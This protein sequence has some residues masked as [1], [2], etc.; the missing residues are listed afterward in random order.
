LQA[1]DS[2]LE[3]ETEVETLL[4]MMG[5]KA[6]FSA[7]DRLHTHLLPLLSPLVGPTKPIFSRKC[8]EFRGEV[9]AR[10]R[11]SGQPC[12]HAER[13]RKRP[14]ATFA[15]IKRPGIFSSV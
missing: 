7:L 8:P 15:S 6:K 1:L 5:A 12:I 9:L 2:L 4:V 13:G 3:V 10:F 14:S 11:V